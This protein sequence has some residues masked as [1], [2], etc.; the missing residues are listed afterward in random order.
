MVNMSLCNLIL[1]HCVVVAACI[2]GCDLKLNTH[3]F[4]PVGELMEG[5]A[6]RTVGLC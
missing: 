2:A 3:S 1:L 5:I 6:G 4:L